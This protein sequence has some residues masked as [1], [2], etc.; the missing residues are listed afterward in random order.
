MHPSAL[1]HFLTE[2]IPR[3]YHMP[4]PDRGVSD[5]YSKILNQ[6]FE[7]KHFNHFYLA[8]ET[9]WKRKMSFLSQ[10]WTNLVRQL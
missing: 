5:K 7:G 2:I 10:D 3:L 4:F 1:N 6:A 9:F 8:G